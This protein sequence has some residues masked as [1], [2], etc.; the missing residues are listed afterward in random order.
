MKLRILVLLTAVALMSSATPVEAHLLGPGGTW[1][2]SSF[3]TLFTPPLASGDSYT[4][5][6]DFHVSYSY[7]NWVGAAFGINYD[8]SEVNFVGVTA[9]PGYMATTS[10]GTPDTYVTIWNPGGAV[11]MPPASSVFNLANV[12]FDAKNTTVANN[13]D[14][15]DITFDGGGEFHPFAIYG[16]TPFASHTTNMGPSLMLYVGFTVGGQPMTAN[17][18]GPVAMGEG[19]W[20]HNPGWVEDVH[21][22]ASMF[23]GRPADLASQG[24]IGVEHVPEPA[25]ALLVL[26][27]IGTL[28]V[29]RRRRKV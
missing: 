27:G 22:E 1:D 23:W 9:G 19:T 26:G 29:A 28:L 25:S 15:D 6:I 20:I 14:N 3:G 8:P 21:V 17:Q 12:T 13:G 18:F 4:A 11:H 2:G 16:A 24:G 7:G 10:P 5:P